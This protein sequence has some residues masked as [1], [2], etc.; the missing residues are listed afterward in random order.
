MNESS[1]NALFDLTGKTAFVNAGTGYLGPAFCE[2]LAEAGA[3]VIC[4]SRSESRARDVAGSLPGTLGHVGLAMD[5]LDADSIDRAMKV[6]DT[7]TNSVDVLVNNAY[8]AAGG[9]LEDVTP[10]GFT[11]GLENATGYFLLARHVRDRAVAAG[12]PASIVML[13]SMYGLVSSNPDV[14]ERAGGGGNPV[15]YQVMKAGVVQLVRH[16][17]VYWA[18]DGIRV[19]CISPGPFNRPQANPRMVEEIIKEVPLRRS[20]KPGELKGA[21]L[22]LASDAGSYITGTNVIVD[23]GWTAK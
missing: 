5:H 21:L 6:V 9:T 22:L 12:K 19:N 1:I 18:R 2:V 3:R 7:L 11:R 13:S 15:S 16:L 17:A 23:G 10:D 8:A 20:G 4:T 14:Y